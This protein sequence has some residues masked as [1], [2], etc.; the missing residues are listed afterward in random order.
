MCSA[1]DS[2]ENVETGLKSG[3]DGFLFKPVRFENLKRV[4]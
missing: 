3:M 1:Y 2:Q 4:L